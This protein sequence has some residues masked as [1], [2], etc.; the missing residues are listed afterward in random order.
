MLQQMEPQVETKT[1]LKAYSKTNLW[2]TKAWYI[3]FNKGHE[4]NGEATLGY[5]EK[6]RKPSMGDNT[7]NLINKEDFLSVDLLSHKRGR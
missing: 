4:C 6:W 5:K 3:T 7:W 1:S 2:R